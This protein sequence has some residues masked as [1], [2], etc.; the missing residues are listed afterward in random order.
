M[1]MSEEVGVA[2][3]ETKGEYPWIFPV[4]KSIF[5]K[6]SWT[7]LNTKG[8]PGKGDGGK[9]PKKASWLDLKSIP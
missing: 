6:S 7:P 2:R 9:E 5:T 1:E 3:K 4:C 8:R